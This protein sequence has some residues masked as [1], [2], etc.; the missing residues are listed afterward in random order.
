MLEASE[1]GKD[2]RLTER[3]LRMFGLVV[4]GNDHEV[5]LRKKCKRQYQLWEWREGY[6]V[7][8]EELAS[9]SVLDPI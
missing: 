9:R 6:L 4:K 3:E 8:P 1:L 2:L 5:D 7:P